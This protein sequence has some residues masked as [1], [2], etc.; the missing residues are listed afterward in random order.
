VKTV[1]DETLLDEVR[2]EMRRVYVARLRRRRQFLSHR[3]LA[4]RESARSTLALAVRAKRGWWHTN[5]IVG[6]VRP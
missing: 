2:R 6:T 3:A 1:I 5:F 4:T